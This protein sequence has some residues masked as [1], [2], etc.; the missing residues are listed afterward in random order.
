MTTKRLM[1]IRLDRLMVQFVEA[2]LMNDQEA[3]QDACRG[4]SAYQQED[5]DAAYGH[6]MRLL[7][8][9][10][11]ML[12]A[13]TEGARDQAGQALRGFTHDEMNRAHQLLQSTGGL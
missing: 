10:R 11:A 3:L 12:R 1:L 2:Q 13:S 9:V 8:A 5:L 4:L 6:Q 7:A